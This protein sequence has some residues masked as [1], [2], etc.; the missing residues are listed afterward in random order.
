M[1]PAVKYIKM[2][3]YQRRFHDFHSHLFDNEEEVFSSKILFKYYEKY[4]LMQNKHQSVRLIFL[5]IY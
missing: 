4:L 3:C 2:F 5:M 1:I